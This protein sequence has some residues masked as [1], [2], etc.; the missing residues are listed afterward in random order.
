LEEDAD[1]DGDDGGRVGGV[2]VAL[3]SYI[4]SGQFLAPK[5]VDE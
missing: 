2:V 3:L 1:E 4:Y 5:R